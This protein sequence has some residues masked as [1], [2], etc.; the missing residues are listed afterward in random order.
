VCVVCQRWRWRQSG[1]RG[2]RSA[3]TQLRRCTI[4][5]CCCAHNNDVQGATSTSTAS[6]ASAAFASAL[7]PGASVFAA[8]AAAAFCCC[9][10]EPT[11][12]CRHGGRR[13]AEANDGDVCRS[14]D[15]T[16]D[17]RQRQ[18]GVVRAQ[19]N[20]K[21][22]RFMLFGFVTLCCCTC[23][24]QAKPTTTAGAGTTTT[25]T[26]STS[27]SFMDNFKRMGSISVLKDVLN[28]GASAST[29]TTG[30]K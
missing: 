15:A 11:S 3:R 5:M 24:D 16:Y 14:I 6:A 9:V 23:S 30:P 25:S 21:F 17:Y 12:R 1:V 10:A 29:S 7:A 19:N 2:N 13:Y 28:T 26:T 18:T 4:V 27:A 20:S 8:A 22:K